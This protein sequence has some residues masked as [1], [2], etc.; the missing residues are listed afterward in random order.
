M[1]ILEEYA[2]RHFVSSVTSE[3]G[4]VWTQVIR[5]RNVGSQV[6]AC[7]LHGDA[8]QEGALT[9]LHARSSR[10]ELHTVKAKH[11]DQARKHVIWRKS[12]PSTRTMPF[13]SRN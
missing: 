3:Y 2:R 4:G 7:V 13:T 9:P 5:N 6:N 11:Q 8:L 10:Q 1:E 12:C